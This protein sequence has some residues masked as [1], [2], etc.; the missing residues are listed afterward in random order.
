MEQKKIY[1]DESEMPKQWYNLGADIIIYANHLLRSSYKSMKSVAESILVNQRS[2]EVNN[3]C[4]SVRN[5]VE[6]I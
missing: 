1:L 6:L 4:A 2:Y 5:I 3:K